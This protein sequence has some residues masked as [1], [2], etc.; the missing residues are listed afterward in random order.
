MTGM[1]NLHP[2]RSAIRQLMHKQGHTGTFVGLRRLQCGGTLE[3]VESLLSGGVFGQS[4]PLLH[5][6][7]SAR[8][9]IQEV[10]WYRSIAINP[11]SRIFSA[12]SWNETACV[13]LHSRQEL[14]SCA[15][16]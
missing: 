1:R 15:A 3:S 7:C 16:G 4:Q 8:R 11:F 9:E 10:F 12:V 13:E 2:L 5:V 6:E 14:R